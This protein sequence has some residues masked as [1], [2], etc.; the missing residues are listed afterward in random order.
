MDCSCEISVVSFAIPPSLANCGPE[1][2]DAAAICPQCLT[3]GAVSDGAASKSPDEP[4]FSRVSDA[5]PTG[6]AGV[7]MALL[8]G[9]LD[10]LVGNRAAI[11]TAL[12]HAE[13]T[14]ADPLLCLDRL[15]ADP[16]VNP[17]VDLERRRVQLESFVY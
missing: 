10:S 9:S 3:V 8:L 15:L 5:M 16:S 6:E 1:G 4:D 11:E 17:H 12:E 2:A 14:G 13:R 7:A